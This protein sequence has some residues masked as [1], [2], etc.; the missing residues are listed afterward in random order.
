MIIGTASIGKTTIIKLMKDV[1][2]TLSINPEYN[3]V[4]T[5]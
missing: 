1:L 3:P 4:E 2:T 5:T